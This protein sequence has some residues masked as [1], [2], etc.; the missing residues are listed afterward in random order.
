VATYRRETEHDARDLMRGV[1]EL[2]QTASLEEAE[3]YLSYLIWPPGTEPPD[4]RV[5]ER[6]VANAEDGPG[7]GS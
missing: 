5:L 7:S 1:A 2:L 3:L 4:P 6:I